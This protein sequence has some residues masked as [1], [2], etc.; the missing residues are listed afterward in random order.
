MHELSWGV[1]SGLLAIFLTPCFA[2]AQTTHAAN[3]QTAAQHAAWLA[4]TGHCQEALPQL[5]KAIGHVQDNDLK[6]K[7]GV[8]GVKCSMAGHDTSRAVSFLVWLNREFPHDAE[9]LYLSSHVY[10]DLSVRASNEL[11]STAPGSPQVHELNA[12]ALET[13]GK[14]KEAAE[15][16]RAV[17]A[18]DPQMPGIHYRLGRLLLSQPNPPPTIKD[19]A[20][21]E[22]EEELKLDPS[23]AGANFVLGELA[24]QAENWQQAVE[25]F[26]KATKLDAGFVDAYLGLGRSLL[27]ANKAAEAVTPL[28][29][30]A[31]L[32]PDNP[33]VHFNLATAYRRA[34]RKADADREFIAHRQASEKANQTSD[35]IKKQVSGANA[36]GPAQQEKTPQ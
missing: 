24:R 29:T 15:E 27:G 13:M 34:G 25:Y 16:Y 17:L 11:L 18:K 2:I 1:T 4:D 8:A 3:P 31:K 33:V 10:S 30:A 35:E 9:V 23:N 32:Q 19:D 26:S 5:S 28:E 7:V 14:W 20:R 12:E 36:E 22:F 6:R 21:R